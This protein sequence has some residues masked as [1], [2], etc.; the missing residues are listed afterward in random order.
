MS[1]STIT[2]QLISR[3]SDPG[4]WQS[5]R[6]AA[7]PVPMPEITSAS[8][9]PDRRLMRNFAR[10]RPAWFLICMLTAAF[11]QA[12]AGRGQGDGRDK[13]A[14]PPGYIEPNTPNMPYVTPETPQGTG[15]YK[16]IM[17]TDPGATEYVFYY[18]A[19]LAALGNKK[20]PILLWGNGSC[21]YAGNHFRNFLT[22]IASHGY[23][24]IAG[25]PMGAP[26]GETITIASNNP[27]RDPE[28]PRPP[29]AAPASPA[30]KQVTPELLSQGIDWAIAENERQGSKF[31]HKLDTSKI[32]VM[33]QSCGGGL[34]AT[35]GSDNRVTTIG[36]WSG[37]T[38]RNT[39]LGVTT[40]KPVLIVTGDPRYDVA[41]YEGLAAFEAIKKPVVFYAWRVNMTH[42]GTYRQ[43]NGGE[44]SPVATAWLDWRLKGD[45]TAAKMFEGGDCGLCTNVHWHVQ[46]R[47]IDEK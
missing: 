40:N 16:A 9:T 41:F 20:M 39:T 31:Y 35:F 47:H 21:A 32:S 6:E 3:R 19:D 4:N 43:A 25:G 7:A 24:A 17:A 30:R 10:V 26:A 14:W 45:K 37:A 44:L 5:C 15:P 1:D 34:A 33:G 27:L 12:P 46:K 28:A 38:S 8:S 23:L 18:P 42:L 2:T 11:A 22:E 13:I 29:V 36:L